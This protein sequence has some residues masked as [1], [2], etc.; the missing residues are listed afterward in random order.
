M[1]ESSFWKNKNVLITGHTGFKGTWLLIWLVKMGAKV[2]GYSLKADNDSLFNSV[3]YKLK[4][5]FIH[6]ESNILDLD[7]IKEYIND[8]QPDIVFHLA[9]QSLVRKS[10]S[11]PLNTWNTNLI[12]TINILEA[13]RLIKKKCSIVI[14]TTDKVYRNNEWLYGYRE[15]DDLGGFDPYSASKACVEIAVNS[16]RSSFNRNSDGKESNI[17]ISTARSGN[18]LGGGDWAKDR[19]MPD[20]IRSLINNKKIQIRNPKSTRPWQHVLEPLKGYLLLAKNLYENPLQYTQAFNFGPS[21]SNNKTVDSLILSVIKHWPGEWEVIQ[22]EINLHEAK[23]LHLQ[24]DKAL[25]L[26]QWKS[27]WGFEKT[28]YETVMW[29]KSIHEGKDAYE[30][31]INNIENYLIDS[32]SL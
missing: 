32:Q 9:A 2:F 24:S 14:I 21:R 8:I 26:L 30:K 29:Y 27:V 11:D 19:I 17:Y 3:K 18:V 12:G 13:S 22:E 20:I 1:Q 28:I 10:Y 31:C 25:Q 6:S 7:Q 16:W 23:L 5:K 4:D 15:N